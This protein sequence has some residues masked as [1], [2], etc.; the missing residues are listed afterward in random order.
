MKFCFFTDVHATGRAPVRRKDNYMESVLRKLEALRDATI[1]VDFYVC[2]GDIF[3]TADPATAVVTKIADVLH[4]FGKPIYTAVGSHDLFNY[5][6]DT[7]ERAAIGVLNAAGVIKI[8]KN[9]IIIDN[10][11]FHFSH[12]SYVEDKTPETY[13]VDT[14]SFD[15]MRQIHVIHGSFYVRKIF[16]AVHALEDYPNLNQMHLVLSG[17]IHHPFMKKVE[18]TIFYNPGSIT[19]TAVDQK[20]AIKAGVIHFQEHDIITQDILLP[21]EPDVFLENQG[22]SVEIQELATTDFTEVFSKV[23]ELRISDAVDLKELI[24]GQDVDDLTKNTCLSILES[25]GNVKQ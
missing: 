7:V 25:V 10:T 2:G 23:T 5:Q 1:D 8:I 13:K 20:H 14:A 24:I 3:H 18:K 4:S 15:G 22:D 21:Y 6:F 12:H 16:D 9:N 19:R 11:V 17:H